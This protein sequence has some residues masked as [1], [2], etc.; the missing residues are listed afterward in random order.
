MAQKTSASASDVVETQGTEAA[1]S[2]PADCRLCLDAVL[3]DDIPE[4]CALIYPCDCAAPVHVGC[5]RRWQEVQVQR[6]SGQRRSSDESSARAST[7]E[8]CGARLVLVGKR[9][10]LFARTAICRPH[11]GFGLVALRRV[12]T[13]SRASRHFAEFSAADG[14]EVEVLEQ[15]VSGE[16]FRVRALKARRYR[17]EGTVAVAQGWIRHIYLEWPSASQEEIEAATPAPRMPAAYAV[18]RVPVRGRRADASL[19]SEGR[20]G[21][22]SANPVP[23]VPNDEQHEDVNNGDD[24]S[25][26]DSAAL[27]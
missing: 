20:H 8:I 24:A 14:Q 3:E 27:G 1:R 15:D 26:T 6:S 7:C 18:P 5:L 16:F 22:V 13:L 17:E 21:D 19:A 10:R 4:N 9:Q 23:V 2:A 11:G 25:S 12:P